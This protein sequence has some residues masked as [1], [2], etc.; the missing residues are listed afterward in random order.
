MDTRLCW[1]QMTRLT[2]WTINARR[3]VG[4][5]ESLVFFVSPAHLSGTFKMR[6]TLAADDTYNV[7]LIE[8]NNSTASE[9]QRTLAE[10]T[11][12]H[13]EQLN[14]TVIDLVLDAERET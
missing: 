12:I 4:S 14:K 9:S 7:A 11:M 3:P 5:D 8:I 1:D 13:V 10:V 6:I 2:K